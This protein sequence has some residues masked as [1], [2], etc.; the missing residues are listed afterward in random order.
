MQESSRIS[1]YS[2]PK[3]FLDDEATLGRLEAAISLDPEEESPMDLIQVYEEIG[4]IYFKMERN[5][6]FEP[7][8]SKPP[9]PHVD[10]DPEADPLIEPKHQQTSAM[11]LKE[12]FGMI[13]DVLNW[14]STELDE[15]SSIDPGTVSQV[16]PKCLP[17]ND[18]TKFFVDPERSLAGAE[19]SSVGVKKIPKNHKTLLSNNT[20]ESVPLDSIMVTV[21]HNRSLLIDPNRS[22]SQNKS[23]SID[24]NQT[25]SSNVPMNLSSSFVPTKSFSVDPKL[26][27]SIDPKGTQ[28]IPTIHTSV[29]P[30]T[31]PDDPTRSS[32]VEHESSSN[33]L[34]RSITADSTSS[35][36]ESV[37]TSPK[38]SAVDSLDLSVKRLGSSTDM[39]LK[40]ELTSFI[41]NLGKLVEK[42]L[43]KNSAAENSPSRNCR[44]FLHVAGM[45]AG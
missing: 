13:H 29:K 28:Y 41:T 12:Q 3:V 14:Q 27:L 7:Y 24:S 11:S 20:A 30:I 21:D 44:D 32:T 39:Y 36:N 25:S 23:S 8:P 19:R 1:N 2:Q 6:T 4:D 34:M 31:S 42:Q 43:A 45:H 15:R 38:S 18:V 9:E 5:G 10:P 33:N 40:G 22:S 16:D 37:K 17:P 35:L 26:P